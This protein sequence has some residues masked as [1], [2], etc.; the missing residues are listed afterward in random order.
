MK[1]PP[2]IAFSLL[3]SFVFLWN[4]FFSP[5]GNRIGEAMMIVF[6]ILSMSY[7]DKLNYNRKYA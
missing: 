5:F 3:M 6:I 7:I 4:I 2:L 1:D